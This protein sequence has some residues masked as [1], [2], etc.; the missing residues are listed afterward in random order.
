M[1]PKYLKQVQFIFSYYQKNLKFAQK[2]NAIKV[3]IREDMGAKFI[4]LLKRSQIFH[5]RT[6]K[7]YHLRNQWESAYHSLKNFIFIDAFTDIFTFEMWD[8]AQGHL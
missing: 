1:W 6:I 3:E 8:L 2:R 5:N 4:A 7:I